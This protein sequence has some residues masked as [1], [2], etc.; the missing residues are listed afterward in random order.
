M[1]TSNYE[2][3]LKKDA[4]KETI[5][6]G[7]IWVFLAALISGIPFLNTEYNLLYNVISVFLFIVGISKLIKGTRRLKELKKVK[8]RT[9]K[10]K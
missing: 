6:Y 10:T 7:I 4:A 3:E 5:M 1:R 9:M 8:F 2:Y